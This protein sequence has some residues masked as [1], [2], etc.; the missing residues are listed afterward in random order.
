MN[1]YIDVDVRDIVENA[2]YVI[3]TAGAGMGADSGL[4]TF[5]GDKGL[6]KTSSGKS[7]SY[8]EMANPKL[9]FNEPNEA[10]GFYGSR[11]NT[12]KKTTPH[13]GFDYLLEMV[14][15]KKDYFVFTSNV[16]GHFQK[17]GFDKNKI[18]E[19]HGS[20][21]RFQCLN[22]CSYDIWEEDLNVETKN[23]MA[24]D[25]LPACPKCGEVSR[26]NILMFGDGD[27]ISDITE[28]QIDRFYNFCSSLSD[29]VV[30]IEIGAGTEISTVRSKGEIL[31]I[32]YRA[33]LIRINPDEIGVDLACFY[34]PLKMKGLEGIKYLLRKD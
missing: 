3:I 7:K 12:Y 10:W 9:F 25:P 13:K 27:W 20:I 5:R 34:F 31:S 16:D 32:R 21:N 28:D 17:A 2:E 4:D 8:L 1:K 15:N 24:L 6:W 11:Y 23:L 30:I 33:P 26:P 19:V 22:L 29:K 14:K 18:I